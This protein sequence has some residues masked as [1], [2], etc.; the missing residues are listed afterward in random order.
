MIIIVRAGL[1]LR[2]GLGLGIEGYGLGQG[3]GQHWVQ[4]VR[5]IGGGVRTRHGG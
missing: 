2:I 5:C 1:D 4:S 3:E